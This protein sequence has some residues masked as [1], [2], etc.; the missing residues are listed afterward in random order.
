M[1][2][3]EILELSNNKQVKLDKDLLKNLKAL[4]ILDLSDNNIKK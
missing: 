4:K 3:L 2:S 1:Q